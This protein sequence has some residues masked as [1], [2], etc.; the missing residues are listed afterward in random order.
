MWD[1]VYDQTRRCINVR[2]PLD[3]AKNILDLAHRLLTTYLSVDCQYLLGTEPE[4]VSLSIEPKL[5]ILCKFND[6]Y[7]SEMS[8][9]QKKIYR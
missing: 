7:T 5:D 8:K 3:R 9:N 6:F 1:I 2:G 4:C